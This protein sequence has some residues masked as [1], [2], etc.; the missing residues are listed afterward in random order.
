MFYMRCFWDVFV[1]PFG[2][3]QNAGSLDSTF[4]F[5]GYRILSIDSIDDRSFKTALQ[6]DGKILIGGFSSF[7]GVESFM[8]ARLNQDG[9]ND[10]SFSEYWR[11]YH[12]VSTSFPS[13]R[14]IAV[15][16]DGK[17]IVTGEAYTGSDFDFATVRYNANGSLDASFGNGGIKLNDI[18]ADDFPFSLCL[19]NSGNIWL[20]IIPPHPI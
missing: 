19:T 15:Q 8:L 17:I 11:C 9:S 6:P 13:V 16:P 3:A 20:R 2:Y 12:S 7:S 5:N 4:D 1:V 18:G 10:L 14:D